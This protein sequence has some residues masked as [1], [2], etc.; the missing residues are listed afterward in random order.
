MDGDSKTERKETMLAIVEAFDKYAKR[1]DERFNKQLKSETVEEKRQLIEKFEK[2]DELLSKRVFIP[3][4]FRYVLRNIM[5]NRRLMRHR[6]VLVNAFMISM[7]NP[8]GFTLREI[9][10]TMKEKTGLVKLD[11]SKGYT[12]RT[13][14]EILGERWQDAVFKPEKS[15]RASPI[16]NRLKPT[17]TVFATTKPPSTGHSFITDEQYEAVFNYNL[18]D[19]YVMEWLTHSATLQIV[20][21]EVLSDRFLLKEES[22]KVIRYELRKIAQEL[23]KTRKEYRKQ[24]LRDRERL[25]KFFK[26]E[27]ES[28]SPIFLEFYFH[29]AS[30]LAWEWLRSRRLRNVKS[31]LARGFPLRFTPINITD[32]RKLLLGQARSEEH[33]DS[34]LRDALTE[35]A[36]VEKSFGPFKQCLEASGLPEVDRGI[37]LENVAIIHRDHRNYKL[38]RLF[39]KNAI[40]HFNVLGNLAA[41]SKRIGDSKLERKYLMKCLEA[42]PQE[43]TAMMLQ[44]E[45]RLKH[46]DKFF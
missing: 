44:I 29:F 6:E 5:K 27:V 23:R 4:F 28:F 12:S 13:V 19:E 25:A 43:N 31:L 9:K 22:L 32:A 41:A 38:M 45:D 37:V 2:V 34:M 10:Q 35:Y 15:P 16:D 30:L 40:Q 17:T 36:F 20:M 8:E 33:V 24:K 42:C 39:L 7:I 46:L 3:G 11:Q 14:Q 26:S 21:P 18:S 1:Y